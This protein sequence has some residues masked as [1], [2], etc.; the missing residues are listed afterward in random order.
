MS[1]ETA[2]KSVN[3]SYGLTDRDLQ[4]ITDIF[5]RYPQIKTVQLFGSRAKGTFHPGSDIDLAIMNKDVPQKIML[6]LKSEFSES[7]LP[8]FVDL[9][10]YP[11]I[12]SDALREHIER[13]G[14]LI[15]SAEH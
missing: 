13:V 9:V 12:E 6:Q 15:Y 7:S 1:V 10:Y 2:A 4:T 14:V 5:T 3:S 8:Y 11:E